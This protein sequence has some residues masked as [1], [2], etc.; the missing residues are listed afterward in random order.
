MTGRVI[1][2]D[3][4]SWQDEGGDL[5]GVVWVAT[6]WEER[7]INNG[8]KA[9]LR[10]RLIQPNLVPRKCLTDRSDMFNGVRLDNLL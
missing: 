10:S 2:T 9:Y 8:V 7:K 3:L 5:R 4:A 6:G 1:L